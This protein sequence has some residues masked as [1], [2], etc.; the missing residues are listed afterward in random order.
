MAPQ[1]Q[2]VGYVRVSTVD[3]NLDRQIEAIGEVD[4]LFQ[5][6]VSGGSGADRLALAECLR[7]IGEGDTVRVASMDRLGP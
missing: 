1:G 3:Q 5:E 4:K 6:K 2:V 7:Y